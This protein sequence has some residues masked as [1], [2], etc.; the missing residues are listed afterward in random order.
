MKST[1]QGDVQPSIVL[2]L[3]I[4][5]SPGPTVSV[6]SLVYNYIKKGKH[7]FKNNTNLYKFI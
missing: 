7:Y 1:S 4:F 3:R 2:T 6:D 5:K